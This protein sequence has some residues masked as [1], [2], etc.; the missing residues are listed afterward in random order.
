MPTTANRNTGRIRPHQRDTNDSA[1][2]VGS[3]LATP[4]DLEAKYNETTKHAMSTGYRVNYHQRIA[5]IIKFWKE[6]APAYYKVGV[7]KGNTR[8]SC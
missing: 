3:D 2:V 6:K 1:T 8:C 4:A 7:K 5:R